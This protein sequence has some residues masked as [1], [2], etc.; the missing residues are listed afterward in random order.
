MVSE[1]VNWGRRAV[2]RVMATFGTWRRRP[3]GGAEGVINRV[4]VTGNYCSSLAV[5]VTALPT[6]YL[7]SLPPPIAA[8]F[9]LSFD[10]NAYAESFY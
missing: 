6:F 5:F 8:V 10:L 7:T 4:L 2:A 9:V 1:L 3:G